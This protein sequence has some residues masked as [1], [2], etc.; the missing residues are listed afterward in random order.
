[1]TSTTNFGVTRE[2]AHAVW[3]KSS[4]SGGGSGGGGNCVEA[5]TAGDFIVVRDS[6]NPKKSILRLRIGQWRNLILGVKNGEFDL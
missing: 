1:M 3:R 4:H 6:K 2:L 5:A